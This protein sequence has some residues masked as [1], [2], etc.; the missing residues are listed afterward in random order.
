[1][2]LDAAL[3]RLNH[4]LTRLEDAVE[5]RVEAEEATAGHAVEVQALADDRARLAQ[6]LDESFMRYAHI[7]TANKDAS[8]RL[9]QAMETIRLV[10]GPKT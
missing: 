8:R 6:E 4:A 2:S 7:Q 1:V 9:D 3:Q 5:R 10:L